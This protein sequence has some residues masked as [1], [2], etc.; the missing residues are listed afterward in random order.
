M[1]RAAIH[2]RTKIEQAQQPFSYRETG[3]QEIGCASRDVTADRVSVIQKIIYR[4]GR[5]TH[6]VGIEIVQRI[7]NKAKN[8]VATLSRSFRNTVQPDAFQ[9]HGIVKQARALAAHDRGGIERA[10]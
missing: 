5:G 2:K 8:S 7:A 3:S 6:T 9:T 10:H 4:A 1:K